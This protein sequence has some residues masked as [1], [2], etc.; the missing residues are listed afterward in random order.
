MKPIIKANLKAAL[1][2]AV[3]NQSQPFKICKGESEMS[4]QTN[5][6]Q[7]VKNNIKIGQP[8]TNADFVKKGETV[9]W[10]GKAAD[11]KVV[12]PQSRRELIWKW[13]ILPLCFLALIILHIR[14]NE[15][16]NM[17][18]VVGVVLLAA[19]LAVTVF[20]KKGR[21][22]KCRYVLTNQRVV[23]VNSDYAYYIRFK[24]LD[25]YRVVRDQTENPTVFFGS[26][27]F[28]DIG[29]HLLWRAA[30]EI[31]TDEINGDE[32]SCFSLVYYNTVNADNLIKTL[33]ELGLKEG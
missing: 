6:K 13:L 9:L 17:I 12:S 5:E 29:G 30:A 2:H 23:L 16:P 10:E 27:I 26:R 15:K 18:M 21:I 3:L 33:K 19:I 28:K 14:F 4:A 32:A 24:D 7:A 25:A 8:I 20:F 1:S 22:M 11:F 31:T